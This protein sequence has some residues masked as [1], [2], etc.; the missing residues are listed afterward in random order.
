[1]RQ[2]TLSFKTNNGG[3]L[4]MIQ[5]EVDGNIIV[6][7]LEKNNGYKQ[8]AEIPAGDMVML[9]N[10]YK[11]IKENDIQNAFI[12][13]HGKNEAIKGIVAINEEIPEK[14]GSCDFFNYDQ[15]NCRKICWADYGGR[16]DLDKEKID[17]E[18]TKPT[19]C[20]IRQI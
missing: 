18:K 13:P 11:Y 10:M 14:C 3:I 2:N 4:N 6:K 19:W 12:N 5:Y 7:R 9:V 8:I 20:P 1:M 15:E 17:I 16:H